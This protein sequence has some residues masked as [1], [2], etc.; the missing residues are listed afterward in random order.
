[1]GQ[2]AGEKTPILA[3]A[4]LSLEEIRTML[5]FSVGFF[6]NKANPGLCDESNV[7][8]FPLSLRPLAESAA[9]SF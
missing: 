6:I 9:V 2:A 8:T 5:G 3:D 1:M 7:P 4:I